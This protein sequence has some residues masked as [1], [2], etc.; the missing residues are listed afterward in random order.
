MKFAINNIKSEM[1]YLQRIFSVHKLEQIEEDHVK[2]RDQGIEI[3]ST[4]EIMKT[5][6]SKLDVECI[7]ESLIKYATKKDFSGIIDNLNDFAQ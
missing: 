5:F 7:R 2:T 4:R 3:K 1:E 6:S